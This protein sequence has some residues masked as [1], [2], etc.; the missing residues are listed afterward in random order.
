MAAAIG[1]G[2]VILGA[3]ASSRMGTPKLLLKWGDTSVLGHLIR[4]WHRLDAKQI[5]VVHADQ[6]EALIAELDR[7]GFPAKDRIA[8]PKPDRGMFSSI[9]SAASWAGWDDRI[10][11]WGIVLGDQPH[12]K[13]S[14]LVSLLEFC[15]NRADRVCQPSWLGK[16]RHPVILP[17]PLFNRLANSQSSNL[18]QF[19]AEAAVDSCECND[20]GLDL[21]MDRPEDYERA[22]KLAGLK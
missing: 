2:V 5:A 9:V 19:L 22:L 4:Q 13:E 21:D 10:S 15:S 7:L 6:D 14:T 20:A 18:K 16:P 3:G 11:H 8:N 1:C 17:R 12:L